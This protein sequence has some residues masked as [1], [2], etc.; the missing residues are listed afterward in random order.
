M[1]GAAVEREAEVPGSISVLVPV[2]NEKEGL[3]PTVAQLIRILKADVQDFEIIIVDD[4]STDGTELAAERLART[5]PRIRVFH[6]PRNNGLGYSYLRGVRE[7]RKS[8]FVY[9]PGDNTWPEASIAEIFRHLGKADVVTSYAT[10]P[11]VRGLCRRVV[12][13]L[14]TRVLNC[15]FGFRMSYY[16]GLTIYPIGFLRTK[17]ATTDGFGFQAETLLKALYGGLSVVEVGVPIDERAAGKSKAVTMRNILSV[18]KMAVRA[19]W[20]LRLRS[21]ARA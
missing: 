17:S 12:S 15:F 11:E 3:E 13:A 5:D 16:N 2:L 4:G 8:H 1:T 9:I 19:Y 20:V 14:Y 7:A 21:Q 18:I 10:N 6:N